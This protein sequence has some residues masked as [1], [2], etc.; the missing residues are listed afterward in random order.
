MRSISTTNARQR[1]GALLKAAQHEAIVVRRRK[2]DMVV[3]VSIEEYDRIR[4]IRTS[5][6]K[7]LVDRIGARPGSNRVP[8]GT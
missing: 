1:F 4:G 8:R 7:R 2:R 3:V 5:K 6:L